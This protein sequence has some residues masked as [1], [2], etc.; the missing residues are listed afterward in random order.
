MKLGIDLHGCLDAS[1]DLFVN[2]AKNVLGMKGE[3]HI[4][5]GIPWSEDLEETLLSYNTGQKYW[6]HFHSI[7]EDLLSKN[8]E[9]KIDEKGRYWFDSVVWDKNKALYCLA[10]QIDLHVDD[11]IEYGYH[12]STP[13]ELYIHNFHSLK[14]D[15]LCNT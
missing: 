4:I 11:S 12:F 13:F 5:T 8:E 15:H 1:P 14:K 3:V 10:N 6:T 9:H 7:V 2:M